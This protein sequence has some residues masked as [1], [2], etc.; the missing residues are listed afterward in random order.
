[1]DPANSERQRVYLAALTEI[2]PRDDG[3]FSLWIPKCPICGDGHRHGAGAVGSDPREY[4]FHRVA[5]CYAI[6][7]LPRPKKGSQIALAAEILNLDL[8][9][10]VLTDADP[11]GTAELL[12]ELAEIDAELDAEFEV[13]A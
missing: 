11:R 3:S 4:L 6:G 1:M 8:E 5:H 13:A 2:Q 7:P 10:Y 12:S 9:S